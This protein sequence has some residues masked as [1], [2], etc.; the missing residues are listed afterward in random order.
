MKIKGKTLEEI[1]EELRRVLKDIEDEIEDFP[2]MLDIDN[3]EIKEQYDNYLD[4]ISD[5]IRFGEL[6]FL[7]SEV[8]KQMDPIAYAMGFRDWLGELDE[9]GLM[10]FGEYRR[11]MEKKEEIEEE[12][13]EIEVAIEETEIEEAMQEDLEGQRGHLPGESEV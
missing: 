7:P 8:L 9:D 6:C 13:A 2:E 10:Q 4:E 12:L 1:A 5:P 11:L 3:D